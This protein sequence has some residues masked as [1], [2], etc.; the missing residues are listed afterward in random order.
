M[1]IEVPRRYFYSHLYVF[2][3]DVERIKVEHMIDQIRHREMLDLLSKG[4]SR[5]Q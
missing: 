3:D 4:S 2:A 1:L 5:R